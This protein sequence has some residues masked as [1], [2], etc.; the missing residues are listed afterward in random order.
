MIEQNFQKLLYYLEEHQIA[1]R[2]GL[3]GCSE[4]EILNLEKRYGITLPA[5]YR[6]YLKTMG[7][8]SGRLFKHDHLAVTYPHI[9]ETTQEELELIDSRPPE[10]AAALRG[11]GFIIASR[12][13]EQFEFIR[14]NQLDD[15]PVWYYN[16]YDDEVTQNYTSVMG[17]LEAWASAAREAIESGYFKTYPD[18]T[19]P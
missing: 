11:D 2:S 16:E 19:A 15:S 17:W 6:L 10:A 12:L 3:I 18:G 4:L 13:G 8:V 1:H 9:L 5:T 14:C 7:H